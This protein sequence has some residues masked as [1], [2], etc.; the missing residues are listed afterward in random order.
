M[1]H[2]NQDETIGLNLLTKATSTD[3]NKKIKK[4]NTRVWEINALK[5]KEL[6]VYGFPDR[7]QKGKTFQMLEMNYEKAF[8]KE[9]Y[10]A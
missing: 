7:K 6:Q 1:L 10:T 9:I 5:K 8:K 4:K 2:R 3:K